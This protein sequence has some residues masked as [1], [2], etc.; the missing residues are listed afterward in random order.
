MSRMLRSSRVILWFL[1]AGLSGAGIVLSG[2]YLYLQ[3]G[4]PPVDEI[5]DVQLQTPLRVFTSDNKLIAEFGEKRRTPL[6]I[7]QVPQLQINAFLAAEDSRF[8][9]HHGVDFKGLVRAAVELAT[10]G[11][12]QSG[13]STITMQVAKNYFLSR[14]Q[15]F[16][17]KFKQI[18]L[19]VQLENELTKN[20]ILELY[21]NKIYLGNRAY[22]LEAA[23]H[24]YYGKSDKDLSL[25]QMAMLA[26]LPKAPSAY[27]P[28]ADPKRALARRNWILQRMKHLGFIDQPQYQ[29]AVRDRITASY[30]GPSTELK[31]PYVAEMARQEM[32]SRFGDAAYTDGYTITLTIDSHRQEDRQQGGTGRP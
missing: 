28:L 22:G 11:Q 12:I 32:V 2:F 27:N 1:L 13:G 7:D 5:R 4:L 10:T 24:V 14:E 19:A 9:Q 31:A 3:P 20:E 18:L 30:H 16:I 15:T 6:T 17:R 21:L 26:G 25:A 23:A 8:Y 29:T